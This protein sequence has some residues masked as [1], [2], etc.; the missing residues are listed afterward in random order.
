MVMARRVLKL[1][2]IT[3]NKLGALMF[4][5]RENFLLA[6]LLVNML[7]LSAGCGET[8]KPVVSSA[9]GQVNSYF[10]GPFIVT[11]SPVTRPSAAAFDHSANQI[12]V[13]S[14]IIT[15][16]S[17]VP[18][19]IIQGTFTSAD[20]GFLAVT[21]SLA[22]NPTNG[23]PSAQNP[24]ITGAWAVEI[25]GAGALADFL[26]LHTSG[27]TSAGPTA[28]AQNTAC[29][30]SPIAAPFLYVTVPNAA[31]LT[32]LADYGMVDISSVGSA[33]TFASQPF[34]IG[35][36]PQTTS[37][38]TGGCSLTNFGSL[39]AYPL[40]TYGTSGPLPELISIGTA[41]LLV[42]NFDPGLGGLG[43]FGGGT[44]VI[45]VA[46][47]SS[48]LDINSVSSAKYNGFIFSPSNPVKQANGYDITVLAS[49]F[50]NHAAVS[51]ACSTLQASLAANNG[52]GGKVP[53]LPSPNSIYGGEFLTVSA[54]GK[55]NDPT[56]ANGSENCDVAIDLG[57]QDPNNNGLFPNATVFIGSNFPPFSDSQP[58]TCAGGGLCAVSFP[59][60]AIVGQ[61]QGNYV[62]FV[63][64]SG[65]STPPAQL[66]DGAGNLVSQPVGIYL[67]QKM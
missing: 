42:S 1:R 23:S 7:L 6:A 29:P 25:P 64:A 48:V 28:T 54:T 45:G 8:V 36:Q 39:T 49:A 3:T 9:N 5:R 50:G 16:G 18:V 33:V 4:P 62:V 53:V 46:E 59:A 20:T 55:V 40:N 67:F 31:L 34:L 30:S 63:S 10:G 26:T 15:G 56:G 52:Q 37:T 66:P 60:A 11:G 24:A 12:A 43:A 44:G 22:I 38:V 47:P 17:Q 32:D 65:V 13:S 41:G 27:P 35:S 57:T 21:E 14:Q 19:N 51:Q 2:R 61:V 58:W